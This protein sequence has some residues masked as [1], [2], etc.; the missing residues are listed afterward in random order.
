MIMYDFLRFIDSPD[1]REFNKDTNFTPAEQAVLISLSD[2][3]TVE[4]KIE[5]LQYLADRWRSGNQGC[6]KGRDGFLPTFAQ[7]WQKGAG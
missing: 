1:I 3:T 5:A 7:I 6:Q 4:E 2:K